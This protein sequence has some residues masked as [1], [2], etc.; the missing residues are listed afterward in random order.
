MIL[1]D[2]DHLSVV[3]DQAHSKHA[4][5][6]AR[7]QASSDPLFALPIVS[8]EEQLR[9]WLALVKRLKDVENQIAAYARL[10]AF[11]DFLRRWTIVPLDRAAADEFKQLRKQRIRIGTP[12]LKIA[13]MALVQ[14]ALLL[15]A[16]L[17]DYRQVP[18]LSVE[19]WL[20]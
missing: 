13:S 11:L 20:D 1:L 9:G 17:R 18:G 16:N 8:V 14:K 12:D 15:S 2:T 4:T 6:M 7:I 19:S 3:A 5:L 10:A